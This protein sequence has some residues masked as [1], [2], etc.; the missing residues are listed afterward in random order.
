MG[1]SAKSARQKLSTTVAPETL[2]YLENLIKQ[3]QAYTLAEAVDL[4]VERL[5]NQENRERLEQ[6]TAAYFD[7]LS[8]EQAEE[9]SRLA[10]ALSKS[11]SGIDF[12][13]EP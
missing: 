5:R 8:P 7:Q 13:R 11:A 4:L 6:A 3:R 1:A 10:A 9:E 12:D 2:S